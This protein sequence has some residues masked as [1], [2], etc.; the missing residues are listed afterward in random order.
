MLVRCENGNLVNMDYCVYAHSISLND[1][2]GVEAIFKT[3]TDDYEA[4]LIVCDTEKEVAKSALDAIFA[5]MKLKVK[6]IDLT[7]YSHRP[8]S[9]LSQEAQMT[10]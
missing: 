10:R 7:G 3:G 9:A 1:R 4:I 5:S 2:Y 6:L 8:N